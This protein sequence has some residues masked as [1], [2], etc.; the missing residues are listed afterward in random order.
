MGRRAF[1][2]KLFS[3]PL[4]KLV[5]GIIAIIG[6]YDLVISQF[7]IREYQEEYSIVADYLYRLGW[8]WYVW[9]I[10]L[11][12]VLLVV[13]FEGSYSLIKRYETRPELIELSA[14][15]EEGVTLWSEGMRCMTQDRVDKW[16]IR[17]LEWRERCAQVVERVD[18]S[19]AGDI[20]TLGTEQGAVYS[21]GISPDHNHKVRMQSAWNNRLEKTIAYIR[22]KKA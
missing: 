16:W 12:A 21:N 8:P 1:I 3:H 13:G 5:S 14:L 4:T 10:L 7:V 22:R 20:R 9:V 2:S 18:P 17:H 19:F 11:L 6:L 15:R